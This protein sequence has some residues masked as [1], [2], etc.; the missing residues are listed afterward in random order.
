MKFNN[1][2]IIMVIHIMNMLN[3]KERGGLIIFVQ[4]CK[5]LTEVGKLRISRN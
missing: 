5:Y 2:I 1:N 4:R 3:L